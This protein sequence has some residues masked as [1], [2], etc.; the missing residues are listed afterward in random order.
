MGKGEMAAWRGLG[1]KGVCALGVWSSE[2]WG[3]MWRLNLEVAQETGD[4][5]GRWTFGCRQATS[6]SPYAK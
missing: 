4:V 5:G 2:V 3:R 1:G 6:G